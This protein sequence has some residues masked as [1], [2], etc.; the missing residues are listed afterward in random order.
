MILDVFAERQGETLRAGV[1][2]TLPGTGERFTYS[3]SWLNSEQSY[4]L[5]LSLP[6]QE[7]PFSS[8]EMR[9]Y[10]EGLLPEGFARN[11]IAKQLHITPHAYI[12]IL[13]QIGGECIGAVS[14]QNKHEP[15]ESYYCALE[16]D[17]FEKLASSANSV[18][19]ET[20]RSSRFSLA[21]A[22]AKVSLYQDEMG[23]WHKPC[24]GAPST[25]IIKPTNHFYA[26]SSINET[27][28]LLA[29]HR[30]GLNVP[31][32]SIID[33]ST[34]M[35]SVERFDRIFNENCVQ[36]NG[37]PRPHRLHQEDL[38]QALGIFPEH[39]YEEGGKHYLAQVVKT[40]RSNSSQ[41]IDDLIALW[42]LVVFNYLI[43]NCD[44]HLKN[45]ALIRN[46]DWSKLNLTPFYDILCTTAY[47][48]LTKDMSMSIGGTRSIDHISRP[49]FE[50]EAQALMLPHGL[51]MDRLDFL[52]NSILDAIQDASEHLAHK[53]V[54][55][56]VQV[57]ENIA[58]DA[59][60]RISALLS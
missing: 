31:Q 53:G 41:A 3:D 29:A 28:C 49:S 15:I 42:D 32:V 9:P 16:D 45:I 4:P 34:P 18:S 11:Y 56:S 7:A 51:T 20:S 1:I 46:A 35:I 58:N 37:L 26:D 55:Q 60:T 2:E 43:G 39:K 12:K 50:R 44:N 57:G 47:E 36:L 24:G 8:R 14:F 6:L 27:I 19:T 23:T 33:T 17:Y 5:S 59:Q 25:H 10:F 40:L 54:L 21:G 52:A 38:C 13:S 48:N 22:Q 30:C